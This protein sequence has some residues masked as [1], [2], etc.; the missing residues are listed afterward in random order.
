M[1]ASYWQYELS[2]VI[3]RVTGGLVQ[4]NCGHI[5]VTFRT[6]NGMLHQLSKLIERVYS[7]LVF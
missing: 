4:W 1:D 3:D 7:V 6:V 5:P 2:K